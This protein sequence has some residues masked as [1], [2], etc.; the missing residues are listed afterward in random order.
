[1]KKYIILLSLIVIFAISLCDMV[2]AN[3]RWY[4]P[5]SITTYI[6]PNNKKPLMKKAFAYWSQVTN[7]KI[8][9]KYVTSPK[10][11]QIV[12]NFVKDA[13]K[14]SKMENAAG[15][16]YHKSVGDRMLEARIEIADNAPNGAAF[17]KDAVYRIMVHEIGHAIGLFDHSN[18]KMSIMYFA[19]GSR[20]QNITADDL[21]RLKF[22]Y[23]W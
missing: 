1:M 10:N 23:G 17:R 13:S 14:T 7:N 6:E 8:M 4:N 3:A 20:N 15:V 12:V 2:M 22:I 19:K 11:A 9:F 18:D 16:T 21:K 5:K